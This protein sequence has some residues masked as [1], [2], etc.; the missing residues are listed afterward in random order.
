M[1]DLFRK[2]IDAG[3]EVR[4]HHITEEWIDIG[5]KEDLAWARRLHE[6]GSKHD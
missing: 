1:P 5:S 3:N 6:N 4:Y 2:L